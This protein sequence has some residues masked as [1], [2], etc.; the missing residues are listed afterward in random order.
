[1]VKCQWHG[2]VAGR[3]NSELE[4]ECLQS[5]ERKNQK[6]KVGLKTLSSPKEV[7]FLFSHYQHRN[8]LL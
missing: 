8:Y 1:M 5:S 3:S 6:T 7:L 4:T 2:K